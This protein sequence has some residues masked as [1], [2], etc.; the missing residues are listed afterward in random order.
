MSLDPKI[1][2]VEDEILIADYIM[3]LLHEEN[4]NKIEM[5]HEKEE[6]FHKM[7]S[8]LPDII[9][10]DI[11]LNGQN[12]GIELA[13]LKNENA[14]IIFL[15]GQYDHVLMSKALKSNPESYLTKPIRKNDL[16]AAIQLAVLKSELK[17]ITIK[18]GINAVKVK[19]DTILFV[20]SDSNYIDIIT[21]T[22]KYTIRMGLNAFL[23]EAKNPNFIR[24]HRSYVVNK[25]KVTKFKTST[26]FIDN[27]EI[28][29]SRGLNLEL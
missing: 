11:N 6:A 1:L 17:T 4:F 7:N 13:K 22:K 5:A 25:T 28:P 15:T 26:V 24:V 8:F 10:M 29:I 3:E 16:F 23:D 21:K 14:R 12:S 27:H 2:I 9:L 18:D 19:L 20:K